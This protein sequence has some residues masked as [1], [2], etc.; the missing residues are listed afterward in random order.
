[1]RLCKDVFICARFILCCCLCV[2]VRRFDSTYPS[3]RSPDF[4][5]ISLY[6]L[7]FSSI[8]Y[9]LQLRYSHGGHYLAAVV[10]SV[11]TIYSSVTLELVASLKGMEKWRKDF[12]RC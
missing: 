4:C 7:P 10:N 9:P 6:S 12:Q 1:M 3:I 11:I 2:I 8:F 5:H